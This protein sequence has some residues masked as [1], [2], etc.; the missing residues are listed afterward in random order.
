MSYIRKRGDGYRAEIRKPGYYESRTFTMLSHAK[1]W[2][3]ER[4]AEIIAEFRGEIPDKTLREAMLRYGDEVSPQKKGHRWEVIRINSL[5]ERS[6][7]S[8]S[9]KLITNVTTPL[10]AKWRDDR[11]KEV[12]TGS[13]LREMNLMCSI[14]EQCRREWHWIK[15]NPIKDVRRPTAPPAR[16]RGV[17]ADEIDRI[18]TALYYIEGAPIKTKSQEVAV[19][20]LLSLETAMRQGEILA[21]K[22]AN[23]NL[24]DRYVTLEK[25]KNGDERQVPLSKKACALLRSVKCKFSVSSAFLGQL[26]GRARNASESFDVHFHDARSEAITR[27]SKI[28]DVLSLARIVGHRD[29]KSLMFYYNET[30]TS[31]A[32]KLD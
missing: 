17:S 9:K 21:L 10:L 19:A 12:S 3:I 6:M 31:M 18:I 30:A 15:I 4:E 28:F 24:N 26:F 8:L 2:A 7:K 1:E 11:L 32:K 25:T 14:F 22:P 16:R 20:F 13:V 27:L 29:L 23:V 5:I